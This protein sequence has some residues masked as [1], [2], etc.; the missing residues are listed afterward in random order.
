MKCRKGI[1][2]FLLMGLFL[3]PLLPITTIASE[4]RFYCVTGPV[5]VE[6]TKVTPDGWLTWSNAPINATF[7]RSISLSY[8]AAAADM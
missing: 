8:Q 5:S 1:A 2:C 3:L 7:T 4:A 6:I